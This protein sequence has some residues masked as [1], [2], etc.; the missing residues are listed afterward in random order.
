MKHL[1]SIAVA[2]PLLVSAASSSAYSIV[3]AA[4][5]PQPVIAGS[6]VSVNDRE[7]VVA[8]DDG[9]QVTVLMDSRTLVPPDLAPGMVMHTEFRVLENGSYYAQRII[10]DRGGSSQSSAIAAYHEQLQG[11]DTY[12]S[13]SSS[14][15]AD[16]DDVENA[17]YSSNDNRGSDADYAAHQEAATTTPSDVTTT[18]PEATSTTTDDSNTKTDDLSANSKLPQTSSSLPIVGAAGLLTLAA[19]SALALR[20]R[21]QRRA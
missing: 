10:P 15:D 14:T 16:R 8:A 13:G 3:P 19:G 2:L 17:S 21:R 11:G 18:E 12:A 1:L 20:R 5:N 6:I 4:L 9:Q 7:M